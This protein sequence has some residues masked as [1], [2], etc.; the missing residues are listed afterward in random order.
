MTILSQLFGIVLLRGL[1]AFLKKSK[2]WILRKWRKIVSQS[3]LKT[4]TP[5]LDLLYLNRSGLSPLGHAVLLKPYEPEL[6]QGTIIIPDN[7]RQ[8]MHM[9]DQRAVVVAV[10]PNAWDNEPSHRAKPGDRVL[11]TKYAGYVT[12]ETQD[13]QLYRLVNDQDIFCRVDWESPL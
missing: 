2:P 13:G 6:R 7:V 12:T 11:V 10:G 3:S 4:A 5:D 8:S 9:A 1:A